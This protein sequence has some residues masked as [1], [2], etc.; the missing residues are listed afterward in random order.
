MNRF[1][2]L[3]AGHLFVT[4]AL[5][6]LM[7]RVALFGDMYADFGVRLPGFSRWLFELAGWIRHFPFLFLPGVVLFLVGDIGVGAYWR[8]RGKESVSRSYM[9]AG[10]LVLIVVITAVLAGLWMPMMN[11]SMATVS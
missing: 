1:I 3:A 11:V 8:L 6:L 10:L 7:G 2:I 5:V 4:V 9:I